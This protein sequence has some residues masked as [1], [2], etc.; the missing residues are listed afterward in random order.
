MALLPPELRGLDGHPLADLAAQVRE[1]LIKVGIPV[2][3]LDHRSG[4]NDQAVNGVTLFLDEGQPY[5]SLA[6]HI[7][8]ERRYRGQETEERDQVYN[9]AVVL[10]STVTSVLTTFGYRVSVEFTDP[11]YIW[12][13][14][15]VRPDAA[16]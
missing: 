6:W 1:D 14:I 15:R 5:V 8:D 3:V 9:A 13:F 11:E 7:P 2:H 16:A 10:T 4:S 12:P